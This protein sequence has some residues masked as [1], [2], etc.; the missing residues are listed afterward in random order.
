MVSRPAKSQEQQLSFF[1]LLGEEPEGAAGARSGR[2]RQGTLPTPSPVPATPTLREVQPRYQDF[3]LSLGRSPHTAATQRIDVGLLA[4]F[5][6]DCPATSVRLDDLRAFVAWLRTE[7]GNDARSLRRKIA[8]VK[9]FFAFLYRE[10][11]TL[12]D[13]SRALLYPA[14]SAR[15]P[16]ALE[17]HEV[18]AV[19]QATAQRPM[20]QALV[21]TLLDAGLKRDEVLA[22]DAVDLVLAPAEP[23]AALVVRATRDAQNLRPRRLRLSGRLRDALQAHLGGRSD[24][25]VFPLSV[26]A[27]NFIVAECGRK[28]GVRKRGPITPQMLRDTFALT[29]MR[30]MIQSE[31]EAA[32]PSG[33]ETERT[34]LRG[35]HNRALLALLGLAEDGDGATRY[36]ILASPLPAGTA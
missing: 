6:Q 28:A 11:V 19:V 26:R 9:G 2:R 33:G 5:L 8:S 16:E 13:P 36:R 12:E 10:G 3:L 7:R 27:I 35:R 17:P 30:G 31:A 15:V 32:P 34:A 29:R 4:T 1:P 18:S 24:G 21:L 22:L 25:L 20:W 14:A 23:D